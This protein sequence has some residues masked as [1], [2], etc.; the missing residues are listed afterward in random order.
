MNQ[1]LRVRTPIACAIISVVSILVSL[2]RGGPRT[3]SGS[4]PLQAVM[5]IDAF[6]YAREENVKT[7]VVRHPALSFGTWAAAGRRV[8]EWGSRDADGRGST[9]DYES[10]K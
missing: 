6:G 10:P 1:T 3:A 7:A 5:W 4:Q 8:C 9:T 2:A